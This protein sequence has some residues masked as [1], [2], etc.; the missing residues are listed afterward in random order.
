MGGWEGNRRSSVALAT[1]HRHDWFSTFGLKAWKREMC[2]TVSSGAWLTL[3][4]LTYSRYFKS[5]GHMGV[6]AVPMV[7]AFQI[8]KSSPERQFLSCSVCTPMIPF[9]AGVANLPR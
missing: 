4:Y 6:K 1:R 9:E 8:G 3:P 7:A 2:S 5:A